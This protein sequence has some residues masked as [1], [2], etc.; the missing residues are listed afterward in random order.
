MKS[1]RTIS[2]PAWA[3]PRGIEIYQRTQA[4]KYPDWTIHYRKKL[5]ERGLSEAAADQRIKKEK[6]KDF[7]L[8]DTERL[9]LLEKL[10]TRPEMKTVWIALEKRKSTVEN[11]V[12][13]FYIAI[14]G[15]ITGWRRSL[16]LTGRESKDY[17]LR[18]HQLSMSLYEIL[19]DVPVGEF[20]SDMD[21]IKL[22]TKEDVKSFLEESLGFS[23]SELIGNHIKTEEDAIDYAHFWLSEIVP[24]LNVV[25][26]NIA[27]VSLEHASN[28]PILKKPNAKKASIHYFIKSMSNFMRTTYKQPLHEVVATLTRV[29]FNDDTIDVDL[30]RKLSKTASGTFPPPK[31]EIP[32]GNFPEKLFGKSSIKKSA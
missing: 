20:T 5:L 15:G 8:A 13:R 7:F 19:A 12:G 24:H 31:I 4:T 2:F 29:V 18:I 11:Y 6:D 17:F 21:P 9:E 10:L 22:I 28:A 23:A 32:P 1:P 14:Q 25:L 16:K 30:V 27:S 26:L 3:P